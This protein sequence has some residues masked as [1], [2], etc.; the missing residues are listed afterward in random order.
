MVTNSLARLSECTPLSSILLIGAGLFLGPLLWFGSAFVL[1]WATHLLVCQ[2]KQ[3]S[4]PAPVPATIPTPSQTANPASVPISLSPASPKQQH[5]CCLPDVNNGRRIF[6]QSDNRSD[7]EDEDGFGFLEER[8]A[9]RSNNLKED[10]FLKGRGDAGRAGYRV[11][12]AID[13]RLSHS[14]FWNE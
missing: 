8:R 7:S 2:L 9:Y 11:S 14:H 13:P 5:P 3:D 4:T 10:R 12:V 6:I 1:I